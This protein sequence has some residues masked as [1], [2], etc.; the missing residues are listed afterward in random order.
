MLLAFALAAAG[1]R[2]VAQQASLLHEFIPPDAREDVALAAT[3]LDGDLPAALQ[4]PSGLATAPDP[5][6]GPDPDR[7]YG[8]GAGDG[9]DS[10]YEPDRDT[11]RPDVESYDDPFSPATA[12]FKRMRAYDAVSP[13][14]SL[15]VRDRSLSR[16][17]VGGTATDADDP[18]YGDYTVDI[19]PDQ[20]VRVPTVG[21]GARLLKVHTVPDQRVF[22]S[23]DGA[24]N[25]FIQGAARERVRVIVEIAI[26]RATFGSPFA[27]VS[28]T[29]I[30]RRSR[31]EPPP[32]PEAFAEVSGAI[33]VSRAS[34][35][36]REAVQ[37]L[38]EY[39]RSFAPSDDP[40]RGRD[41]IYVDLALSK[42]GVCRHRSFAFLVSA[43]HLGLPT[44][45]VVNEAHAWVE[46]S[47][48][49]IWH[50]IDLGG[51]ARNLEN[52]EDP[53]RPAHVPPPDPYA[54]A[55]SR[56]SGEDLA[57]R[58]REG[59]PSTDPGAGGGAPNPGVDAADPTTSLLTPPPP[60]APAS[61]VAPP[62]NDERPPATVT[63]AAVDK[64]VRRG[65]P[66][67]VTGRVAGE[68]GVPCAHA[69]VDVV[70]VGRA[71]PDGTR[72]GSLSTDEGGEYDGAVVVPRDLTLGDYEL[73]VV[74]PGSG[75]CGWGRSE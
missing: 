23:R 63:V 43:L 5:R 68:S 51:A 29:E 31:V 37:R 64:D 7:A 1:T 19:G 13:D 6:S 22:F 32:H 54:W 39:F 72:L 75:E 15:R 52:D 20:P 46:V 27:D 38:V 34:T 48:T 21:P 49:K 60:P 18:F 67:H 10:T 58:S 24:D 28:W 44:R 35:S 61:S 71:F 2:A 62:P 69:R 73:V 11:R 16:L 12:P 74:T 50:R 41:D 53:S 17:P 8:G 55:A 33:G 56:D 70:L 59:P 66:L 65:L 47:D 40:P 45:M 36:P 4:T 30:D 57:Q 14:Y 25:W 26:P 3:T 42:K 9:P